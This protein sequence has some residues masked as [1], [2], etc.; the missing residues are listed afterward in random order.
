MT[1]I[2]PQQ[3]FPTFFQD[4]VRLDVSVLGRGTLNVSHE[5]SFTNDVHT[6]NR[7]R[8]RVSKHDK[9]RR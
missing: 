6:Q 7:R 1:E 5:V 8:Q 4:A 9:I 2:Y 3:G